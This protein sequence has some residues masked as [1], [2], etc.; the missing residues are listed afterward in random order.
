MQPVRLDEDLVRRRSTVG[1]V[2]LGSDPDSVGWR[3]SYNSR[4]TE[5]GSDPNI[6]AIARRGYQNASW[7][8]LL[9]Q[10]YGLIFQ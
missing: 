6:T 7:C 4:H 9:H 8:R 3:W 2:I 10:R 5:S 1:A